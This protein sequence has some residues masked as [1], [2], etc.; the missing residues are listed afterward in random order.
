MMDAE[1]LDA[2]ALAVTP[3]HRKALIE[4]AGRRG[5]PMLIEK[6][7]SSDVES[8]RELVDLCNS[9][10]VPCQVEFPLR[11]M[12]SLKRLRG[13]I[14]GEL[15]KGWMANGNL[16]MAWLPAPETQVWDPMNHNGLINECYVHLFDT[17]AFLLGRPKRAFAIGDSFRGSPLP[18]AAAAVIE[19]DSGASV[20]LTCGGLGASAADGG[21]LLEVWTAN[22]MARLTGAQWLPDTLEWATREDKETHLEKFHV[23][24]RL[25]LM[26]Y[27]MRAF[28]DTVRH[29]VAPAATPEDGLTATAVAMAIQESIAKREPVEVAY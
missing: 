13:L 20:A 5:I 9:F 21:H 14:D 15:G 2:I 29:G 23:P 28:F 6:P 1:Q 17:L 11:C 10:D 22:G 26:E 16:M 25:T 3:K 19:F 24:K 18:D 8:G 12:P 7:W 27:N 4:S